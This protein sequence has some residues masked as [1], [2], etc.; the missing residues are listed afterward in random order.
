M[1]LTGAEFTAKNIEWS[2]PELTESNKNNFIFFVST[3]K[4]ILLWNKKKSLHFGF[5]GTKM[6]HAITWGIDLHVVKNHLE[7]HINHGL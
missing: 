1:T 7:Q 4:I 5:L 3:Q 6:Y 2:A